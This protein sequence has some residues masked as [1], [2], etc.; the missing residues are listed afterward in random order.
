MKALGHR[1]LVQ[2]L[3]FAAKL[4]RLFVAPR[5]LFVLA[6]VEMVDAEIIERERQFRIVG[7]TTFA[8]QRQGL[9]VRRSGLGH[10]IHELK[11]HRPLRQRVRIAAAV[12]SEASLR[13]LPELLCRRQRLIVLSRRYG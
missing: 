2:R 9:L 8:K 5:R 4:Q 1:D 11:Y 12:Q 3:A 10:A 6:H 13:D 7:R